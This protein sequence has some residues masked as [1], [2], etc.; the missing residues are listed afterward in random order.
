MTGGSGWASSMSRYVAAAICWS[1]FYTYKPLISFL[2]V[3]D[4]CKRRHKPLCVP[5]FSFSS[6]CPPSLLLQL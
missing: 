2:L 3:T 1:T 6:T 4:S 5:L